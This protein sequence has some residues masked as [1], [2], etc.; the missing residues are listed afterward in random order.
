MAALDELSRVPA[1]IWGLRSHVLRAHGRLRRKQRLETQCAIVKELPEESLGGFYFGWQRGGW[2]KRSGSEVAE[3][4]CYVVVTPRAARWQKG[5]PI[6]KDGR[7][8]PLRLHAW[9]CHAARGAPLDITHVAAHGCGDARCV[10]ASHIRWVSRAQNEEE[11]EFHAKTNRPK[12]RY[13]STC[14]SPPSK[15]AAL[16]RGLA[17]STSPLRIL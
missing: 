11:A 16:T 3:S 10:S 17:R 9:V 12:K 15:V 6:C 2:Q 13:A 4:S 1:N 7:V 5:W 14:I 8:K